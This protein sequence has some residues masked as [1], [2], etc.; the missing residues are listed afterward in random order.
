MRLEIYG[1]T[2]HDYCMVNTAIFHLEDGGTITIDRDETEYSISPNDDGTYNLSMLWNGC[3]LWAINDKTVIESE[4]DGRVYNLNSW[5]LA[6]LLECATLELSLEDDAPDQDYQ[7]TNL[8]WNI[9]D[10]DEQNY[11]MSGFGYEPNPYTDLR[12]LEDGTQFYV[13]NGRWT[14]YVFSLDGEKYM[15]INETDS[16]RKLTG[17]EDLIIKIIK[18][19]ETVNQLWLVQG[20]DDCEGMIFAICTTEELAK[21]AQ[22]MINLNGFENMTEVIQSDL[23]LNAIK[24]DEKVVRL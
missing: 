2:N 3:Y 10:I 13:K 18:T 23:P 5:S 19:P 20:T 11:E 17:K 16:N 24:T 21:K 22:S 12:T 9:F 6:R 14:G 7:I 4:S 8:H 1:T 15:H